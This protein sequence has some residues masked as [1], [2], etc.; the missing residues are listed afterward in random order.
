MA[1]PYF[2]SDLSCWPDFYKAHNMSPSSLEPQY[3]GQSVQQL[4]LGRGYVVVSSDFGSGNG[5][6]RSLENGR[7]H[8]WAA[9][10]ALSWPQVGQEYFFSRCEPAEGDAGQ[11]QEDGQD[12]ALMRC[13]EPV[14]GQADGW[15][16]HSPATGATLHVTKAL[17]REACMGSRIRDAITEFPRVGAGWF[18]FRIRTE[19]SGRDSVD[20]AVH[21]MR[22]QGLATSGYRPWM[23]V[24]PDAAPARATDVGSHSPPS[25]PAASPSFCRGWVRVVG[26]PAQVAQEAADR[27]RLSFTVATAAGD[28]ASIEIAHC[29]AYPVARMEAAVQRWARRGGT[30]ARGA[31]EAAV[32]DSSLNAQ[33]TGLGATQ[34]LCARNARQPDDLARRS[35]MSPTPPEE[36]LTSGPHPEQMPPFP[37]DGN[38][39]VVQHSVLGHSFEGREIPLLQISARAATPAR[40][41]KPAVFFSARAHPSETPAS[42]AL[43]AAI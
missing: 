20:I 42:F 3:S 5:H 12:W 1:A 33:E 10:P 27:T 6:L 24:L 26:R 35:V 29:A 37:R 25:D 14:Q 18:L 32:L 9:A 30:S 38:T 15:R 2:P 11:R 39:V 8:V 16:F 21:N 28:E 19:E 17:W 34:S 23:R 41:P 31:Q 13:G 40:A 7:L 22:Q 4:P 36:A 43:E